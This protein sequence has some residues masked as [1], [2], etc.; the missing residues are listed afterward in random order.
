[1]LRKIGA[2][3]LFASWNASSPHGY[4]LT[5]FSACCRR[6][7]LFSEMRR[8]GFFD[9]IEYLFVSQHLVDLANAK[10]ALGKILHLLGF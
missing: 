3:R 8:F 5:G 4:Q 7:G 1:M 10:D 2:S 9:I 6:Y